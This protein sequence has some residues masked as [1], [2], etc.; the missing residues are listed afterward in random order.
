M[1]E[2]IVEISRL[3]KQHI[4]YEYLDNIPL[5]VNLWG[6]KAPLVECKTEDTK[7]Y[8]LKYKIIGGNIEP[9]TTTLKYDLESNLVT[10]D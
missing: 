3:L 7:L 1:Q 9:Y 8:I 2:G 10:F 6:D 5:N 4:E